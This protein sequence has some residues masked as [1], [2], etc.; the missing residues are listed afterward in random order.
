MRKKEIILSAAVVAHNEEYHLGECLKTLSFADEIVVVLDK[1]NDRSKEIALKYTKNIIEGS[2]NIE[3]ERRNIALNN[4]QGN[5]ILELDADE[6]ISKDLQNEILINIKANSNC[7]FEAKINNH[8]GKRSI[9]NGWLRSIAVQKRQF[10]H[11][12]GNKKYIEDRSLHPIA[13][14]IGEVKMLKSPIIHYMDHDISDLLSRFNRYTSLRAIDM[15]NSKQKM[16]K[17]KLLALFFSFLRRFFKAL[18]TNKGYKEGGLGL[19]I[20]LL[21]SSYNL[22]SYLKAIE[23][24]NDN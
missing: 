18:I 22:V 14:L 5:W 17:R 8:I 1:C 3:G 20:S 23:I 24:K 10:I 7:N 6:R 16:K 9:N 13:D 11:Y 12:N 15:A 21:S 4:C 19:L 2:W